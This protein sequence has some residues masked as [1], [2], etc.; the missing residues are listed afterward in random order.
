MRRSRRQI[1]MRIVEI[2]GLGLV[3]LDIALYFAAYRPLG[4]KLASEQQR[5]TEERQS[6]RDLQVRID[7]LEKFQAALPQAGEQFQDFMT[8][9]APPRKRGF[10]QAAHLIRQV[11]EASGVQLTS[12]GYRLDSQ[13][14]DPLERLGLDI[15][16]EGPYAKMIKFAHAL[17]TAKEF[18]VIREFS[19]ASG[20]NGILGLRL[21]ADLYLTP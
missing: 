18:I 10:S 19:L 3:V 16:V 8:A 1:V 11:T 20:E 7:Q 21:V 2:A 5:F 14:H 4:S 9:S 12:V 15:N 6:H 17:E 13:H